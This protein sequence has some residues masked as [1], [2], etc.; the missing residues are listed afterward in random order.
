MQQ[1]QNIYG[2]KAKVEEK[3]A[4]EEKPEV[5]Q[6][7]IVP[8]QQRIVAPQLSVEEF[9]AYWEKFQQLKLQIIEKEDLVNIQGRDFVKKSGWRKLATL[10]NISTEILQQDVKYDVDGYVVCVITMV[11]ATAPN[12][13]FA[14]GIGVCHYRE[15]NFA[16]RNHDIISVSATRATNRAISDLVGCAE[17]SAE[18]VGY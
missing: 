7:V 5:A 8:V 13:R 15:R 18:E 10:F 6:G 1:Q 9:K 3:K 4:E 2:S 14:D 17:V 11:R 12:G 16:H